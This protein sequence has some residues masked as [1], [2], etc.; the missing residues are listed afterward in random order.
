[1]RII[2]LI[3][4]LVLCAV[5]QARPP[6]FFQ[7][8]GTVRGI[9]TYNPAPGLSTGVIAADFDNDGDADIFVP[10]G[11]GFADQLYRNLGNGT[12]EE[13]A[14]ALGVASMRNDRAALFFDYDF[15]DDLDLVIVT[16]SFQ[17]VALPAQNGIRLYR[18][19]GAVFIEVTAAAGLAAPFEPGD[20]LHAGG[21]S[22]GD[23]DGDG[24]LDLV[25][26]LWE[27]RPRVFMNDGAGAFVEA[28]VQTG[29]GAGITTNWQAIIFDANGDGRMDVLMSH[30]FVANNLWHNI[31]GPAGAPP[32]FVD[33][34][35]PAAIDSAFNEMGIAP[36]DPDNDGDIDFYMTNMHG[37]DPISGAPE[38]NVLFRNDSA[39]NAVRFTEIAQQ[40]GVEAG[41]IGWGAV[42][43]D[44]DNDGWQDLAEANV[45]EVALAVPTKLWRN[46]SGAGF[47][48]MAAAAGF[49]TVEPCTSLVAFDSDLDG[50]LDLLMPSLA[51]TLHLLENQL[52]APGQGYLIVR[53]RMPGMNRRAIGAVVRISLADGT[54][55]TR[56]IT[57]GTSFAGQ[58]PAEAFFG[59]GNASDVETVRVTWP[60]GTTSTMH[61]VPANQILPIMSPCPCGF[62]A[63]DVDGDGDADI[64]DLHVISQTPMDV[65]SDGLANDADVK[66]VERYVRKFERP[67]RIETRQRPAY[68][69]SG[70]P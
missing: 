7:E 11:F 27:A 63:L 69:P 58:Q 68:Q 40:A 30:D 60:D 44:F 65:N 21:L 52:N 28:G 6:I 20:D 3:L 35:G 67:G 15:D 31:G 29:I 55:M 59:L 25:V 46:Q 70:R 14:N 43:A 9:G 47:L 23:L 50:D 57:A 45:Q 51:G 13:V 8:M 56:L 64:N 62:A 19:D 18:N 33:I 37:T 48:E 24:D 34:A 49:A 54:T 66:C 42:F 61:N 12:Y 16:D 32:Q 10:S 36:G 1:M 4:G 53:P 2:Q 17:D 22:A 26:M 5:A 41:G 38:Y 39:G